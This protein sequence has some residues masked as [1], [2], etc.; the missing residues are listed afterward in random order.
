MAMSAKLEEVRALAKELSPEERAA[1]LHELQ[2]REEIA[3]RRALFSAGELQ[4]L[5]SDEL[6]DELRAR[7]R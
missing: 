2:V 3:R 4:E 6:F 1:L 5:D 7:H